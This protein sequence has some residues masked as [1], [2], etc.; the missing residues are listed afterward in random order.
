MNP[1]SV[2]I[3]PGFNSTFLSAFD[4]SYYDTTLVQA[5][6]DNI[7][8][9]YGDQGLSDFMFISSMG[10]RKPIANDTYYGWERGYLNQS[11][12]ANPA[13]PV[14]GSG[15]AAISFILTTAAVTTLGKTFVRVNDVILN[16][17]TGNRLLVTAISVSAG[18]ATLTVKDLGATSGSS[19]TVTAGDVFAIIGNAFDE[20]TGQ[21]ESIQNTWYKYSTRTQILKDTYSIS[22]SMNTNQPQW[23]AGP[24]GSFI[25]EGGMAA[26]YR[27][28]KNMAY[29]MLYG[30]VNTNT[31]VTQRTTTGLDNEIRNR[32]LIYDYGSVVTDFTVDDLIAV[33]DQQLR[34]WSGN[35]FLV[36]L[37]TAMQNSLNASLLS[38]NYLNNSNIQ[39]ATERILSNGFVGSNK[40]AVENLRTTLGWDE[41]NVGGVSFVVKN[42]AL[43][44][45]PNGAGALTT[46]FTQKTGYVIPMNKTENKESGDLASRVQL[47]YK[48]LAGNNRLFSVWTDGGA[49]ARQI[50]QYDVS[51]IYYRA[52]YGW[53][54]RGME[55]FTMLNLTGL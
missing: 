54:F 17:N 29:T 21:P 18:V 22:G 46:G 5:Y 8:N 28:A 19:Y 38:A 32:G 48:S 16:L 12:T 24:D 47:V 1:Q 40:D 31:T 34:R 10:G 49:S 6:A 52:E 33:K 53:M 23:I 51:S 37:P 43:L 14:T 55:Q 7:I 36:W 15:T 13:S 9:K 30:Q 45:D 3:T 39:N 50:G 42:L 26:E 44:N 11:I 41:V 20:G 25:S 4:A 27:M 2:A 35:L